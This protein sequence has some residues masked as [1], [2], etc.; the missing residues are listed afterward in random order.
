MSVILQAGRCINFNVIFSKTAFGFV[1][2]GAFNLFLFAILVCGA[3]L[4]DP[5]TKP[6]E[7]PCEQDKRETNPVGIRWEKTPKDAFEG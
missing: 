6:V 5:V 2:C 4:C 3:E 7:R 1:S